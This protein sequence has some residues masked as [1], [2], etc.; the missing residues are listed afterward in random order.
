MKK[1]ETGVLASQELAEK[2]RLERLAEWD[3]TP[4]PN[5]RY[6]GLTP[7]EAARSL[8]QPKKSPKG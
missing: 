1:K 5:S 7:G 6:K 4:S 8:L 2:E 3:K